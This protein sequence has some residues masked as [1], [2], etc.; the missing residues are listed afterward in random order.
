MTRHDPRSSEQEK[1]H[2]GIRQEAQGSRADLLGV[3]R[4]HQRSHRQGRA[5]RQQELDGY[6]ETLVGVLPELGPAAHVIRK[7]TSAGLRRTDTGEE[8]TGSGGLH[9]Y[10]A[11][12]DGTD[13]ER[14]LKTLHDRCWLKGL[15]WMWVSQSGQ[16]LQRSIVDR[17]VGG[18]ERLVFEGPPVVEP[19]LAQDPEKRR[20]VFITGTVIDSRDACPS[21]SA[22]EQ[23]TLGKLIAEA[24]RILEPERKR[25]QDA[26]VA[27]QVERRM[28]AGLSES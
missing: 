16:L 10:I 15:G 18:S 21:L 23:K 13:A 6:W 4:I 25:A 2:R 8:I 27:A 9:A 5:D 19:P 24:S 1:A 3:G 11:I 7:S 22:D 12:K 20:P 26:F 17:M 14:L 28:R